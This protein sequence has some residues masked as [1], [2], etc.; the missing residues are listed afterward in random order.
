[1]QLSQRSDD[2]P[3]D[4]DGQD[5]EHRLSVNE[6]LVSPV[7][8]SGRTLIDNPLEATT[9]TSSGSGPTP[10]GASPD[11]LASHKIKMATNPTT[12]LSNAKPVD[13]TP[14]P[15]AP[16]QPSVF[17]PATPSQNKILREDVFGSSDTDLSELSNDSEVDSM[18]VLSQKAA[19]RTDSMVAITKRPFI[20]AGA[21]TSA[22]APGKKVADWRILDSDDE[23]VLSNSRKGA[24]GN[25]KLGAGKTKKAL[26]AIVVS[27]LEDDIPPAP[28]PF[29]GKVS[30][31]P[32]EATVFI[33]RKRKGRRIHSEEH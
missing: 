30:P 28:A 16:R 14:P 9:V 17:V 18:K 5:H 33:L 20:L 24:K 25:S 6:Q 10:S 8:R 1:M 7:V 22:G 13:V 21:V 15:K 3:K 11:L 27:D 4:K 2:S 12:T 29:K 26:P 23:E 19:A 32:L 31:L